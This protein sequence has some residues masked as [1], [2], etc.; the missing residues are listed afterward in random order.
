MPNP[1]ELQR[2]EEERIDLINKIRQPNAHKGLKEGWLRELRDIER[3]LG[4]EGHPYNSSAWADGYRA[5]DQR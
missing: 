4:I 2:L 5:E 3:Q 1:S